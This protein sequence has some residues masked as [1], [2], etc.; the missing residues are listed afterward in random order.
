MSNID[1]K[2]RGQCHAII[3]AA[4]VSAGAV[5]AGLAQIPCSDSAII[6]PIQ[7]TM[8]IALGRVFGMQLTQSA[9]EASLVTVTGTT[10]GR[11]ISQVLVGWIPVAGNIINSCTAASVTE[12]MGWAL[13]EDFARATAQLHTRA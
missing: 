12:T 6:V 10:I 4:S 2:L 3:H 7:I 13:A 5:G 9:A 8:T 1:P 11:A